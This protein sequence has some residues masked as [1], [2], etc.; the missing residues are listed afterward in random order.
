MVPVP[1]R[2]GTRR[3]FSTIAR[4]TSRLDWHFFRRPFWGGVHFLT[5][6][7]VVEC[8]LLYFSMNTAVVLR[9]L[10]GQLHVSGVVRDVIVKYACF[11][12]LT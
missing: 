8:R 11:A 1:G 12:A 6:L 9:V 2:R 10:V 7:L 3:T 4:T 5:L